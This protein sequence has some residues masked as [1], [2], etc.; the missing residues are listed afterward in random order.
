MKNL[1][2]ILLLLPAICIAQDWRQPVFSNENSTISV[3]MGVGFDFAATKVL[4]TINAAYER[5]NIRLE[6]ELS[7][8]ITRAS[9]SNSFIGLKIGYDIAKIFTPSVGY[10]H[11]LVSTDNKELNKNY[12]GYSA[13]LIIPV[14]PQSGVFL[15][16]LYIN[17]S[18]QFTV[19][20]HCV[21]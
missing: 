15:N 18:M 19:G 16:G 3:S 6:G 4:G 8:S 21:L 1:F 9:A 2:I 10:Y 5:N 13:K 11:N 7:P 12:F 20:A 14:S 17:K